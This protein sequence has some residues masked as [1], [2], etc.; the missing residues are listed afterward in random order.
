MVPEIR[1]LPYE[2]R[3][4]RMDLPSMWY[5]QQRADAIEVWKFLNG[6]YN[7]KTPILNWTGKACDERPDRPST[8]NA[9]YGLEKRFAP[10]DN[11]IRL[12]FFSY[13][14]VNLWN[15]LPPVAM[16]APSINSFKNQLDKTWKQ[17]RYRTPY[18]PFATWSIFDYTM[19]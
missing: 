18:G 5:R 8:R 2:E 1:H 13:R 4:R 3:L 15:S 17:K 19:E 6:R 7:V 11:K 12:Q 14:V 10:N 16:T 9:S